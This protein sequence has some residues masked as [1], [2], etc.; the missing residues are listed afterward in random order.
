MSS[1]KYNELG[2][3]LTKQGG[4]NGTRF[5]VWAPNAR[6]VSVVCESNN[7]QR[8]RNRL[9]R[10]DDGVWSSFISGI[11][12]GE[13][14]KY[15]VVDVHGNVTDKAD[16]YA[17]E[18]EYRPAT[19]SI[20]CDLDGY[21]WADDEWMKFRQSANWLERPVSIYEV[22]PGSWRRPEDG[23]D[24]FT[25]EELADQLIDYCHE[26]GYSHLQLMPV[27]EHPFDGS[28]GY[29]VTGYFAPTSRF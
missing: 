27:T 22:H 13:K 12:P 18:A 29:Q 5:A 6:E 19:A 2:A 3:H 14:Y 8:D 24:Y 4:V 15:S 28:W 10:G 17:F 21:S 20:V 7:W 26:L 1:T 16:P 25:W 9:S 11:Q 23:R